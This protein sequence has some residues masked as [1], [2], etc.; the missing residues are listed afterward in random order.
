MV[1]VVL[2]ARVESQKRLQLVPVVLL[3]ERLARV[4]WFSRGDAR[5]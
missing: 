4:F 1:A 3:L 5:F 2:V